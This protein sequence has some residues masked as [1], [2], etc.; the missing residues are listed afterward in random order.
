MAIAPP[1]SGTGVIL[2]GSFNP[3]I[4]QPAWF[5]REELI[6]NAEADA[7]SISIIHPQ[8]S[9]FETESFHIQ[10]T[11]DTFEVVARGR[12]FSELTRDLAEGTFKILHHTPVTSLGINTFL[13]FQAASE[14]AWNNFGHLLAPKEFWDPLIQRPGMQSLT[15]RGVR[16]DDLLGYI[17]IRVEPSIQVRPHGIFVHVNDHVQVR[18]PQALGSAEFLIQVLHSHWGDALESA[19][20]AIRAIQE[21]AQ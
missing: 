15:V 17:D 9:S 2:R 11:P 5:A 4:F 12:A 20:R 1:L 8:I 19:E 14:R 16:P 6:P 10:V 18:D 13:H 3:S 21:R 7:A